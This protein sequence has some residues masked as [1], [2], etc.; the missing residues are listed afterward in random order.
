MAIQ[1]SPLPPLLLAGLLRWL[2]HS[3]PLRVLLALWALRCAWK[4]WVGLTVTIGG[5]S[6]KRGTAKASGGA[7]SRSTRPSNSAPTAAPAVQAEADSS[8]PGFST[9]RAPGEASPPGRAAAPPNFSAESPS[10]PAGL[11]EAWEPLSKGSLPFGPPPT[12]L[13][14]SPFWQECDG[15]VFDVRNIRY[16]QTKEKVAS[17]YALYDCIGM[18]SVRDT[19]RIDGMVNRLPGGLA[20][21]PPT[22]AGHP[23]WDPAWGVPRIIAMNCQLPYKAGYMF[24]SHPEDD[25]GLSVVSYF[26]LSRAASEILAKGQTSPALSLFRRLVEEG[27]SSKDGTALKVVGRVDDMEKYGV[28]ESWQRFNNKPVLLTKTSKMHLDRL[29]EVLEMDYDVRMWVYLARQTLVNYH[30]LS[31]DAEC[32][33]GYVVEGKTDDELPE[34]MLGCFRLNNMDIM[35]AHQVSVM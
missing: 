26:A 35:A 28:P 14:G 7:P 12:S 13:E 9:P 10:G 30:H 11:A 4:W 6:Y 24:G 3:W 17:D 25:G 33:I 21:L 32:Q 27:V 1:H 29:P 5:V 34:Q 20:D 23:P 19:R 8:T 16:K 2:G 22:P 18:D 31:K 15:S